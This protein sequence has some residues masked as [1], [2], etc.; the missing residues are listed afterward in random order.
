M[1]YSY[2]A[3]V[4]LFQSTGGFLLVVTNIGKIVY[5]TESIK[6]PFNYQQVKDIIRLFFLD[7]NSISF[8]TEVLG[9][10]LFDLL[11][12]DDLHLVKEQLNSSGIKR[13]FFS[14]Q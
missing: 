11:H 4:V 3:Y 14:F 1:V 13:F 10:N 9:Q 2:H 7:K 6:N 8:Q 5:V 12:N